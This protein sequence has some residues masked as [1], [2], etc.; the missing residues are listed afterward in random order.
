[1]EFKR[2]VIEVFGGCNYTCK[3]CPQTSPGRE[4]S[5]LRRMPL[6]LFKNILDQ[7][8]GNPVINLE[9]SGEPTL[10]PNLPLYIEECS[11]RGFRPFIYS[12]G[13]GMH[14]D[15][16]RD[17]IDAGLAL[18]RFS[19]I[20]Y[21]RQKY[22]EWMN[23]DNW[24]L[25]Y[26]NTCETRDYIKQSGSKCRLD[27][28]HLILD[29]TRIQYEIEQYQQNYIFPIGTEAYIW[30]M[31]NWSGNWKPDYT[32]D[33]RVKRSCGR[34]F[35]NEITF[36]AGG[37]N[38][39]RGAVTPCCQTLGPPNESS[40]VLGHASHQT[41]EEIFYGEEYNRLRKAHEMEDWDS[42]PFCRDCDFLY[43][44]PEVL[45]WSNSPTAKIGQMVGTEGISL[46]Q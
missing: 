38:G 1:M 5:F 27:S 40:S 31:H 33:T 30:K 12:N 36:R 14:G 44:D 15:F 37:I 16:M 21:N 10:E 32:R 41:I 29:P 45:V 25:I 4:T 3:M 42:V 9:G 34:P 46:N 18:Y 24:D 6:D 20:G 28:Y 8:S 39:M 11:R 26:Q 35:A 19:V 17:C 2:A 22:Q 13:S 23:V 7:I 43:D